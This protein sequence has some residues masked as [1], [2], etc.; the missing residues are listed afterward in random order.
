MSHTREILKRYA[1]HQVQACTDDD[2]STITSVTSFPH[3]VLHHSVSPTDSDWLRARR[4]KSEHIDDELRS[5]HE[6]RAVFFKVLRWHCSGPPIV[7]PSM[8]NQIANNIGRQTG[9]NKLKVHLSRAL[10][11]FTSNFSFSRTRIYVTL[12]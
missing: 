3:Y 12:A 10:F 4:I 2:E 6:R 7:P 5:T 1:R 9:E 11:P 8:S